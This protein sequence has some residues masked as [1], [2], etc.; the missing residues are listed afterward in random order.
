MSPPFA[1]LHRRWPD[2]RI[3][4]RCGCP[5]VPCSRGEYDAA[6][7]VVSEPAAADATIEPCP[8]SPKI[9]VKNVS[10]RLEDL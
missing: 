2:L 9:I 7:A 4:L 8:N 3:G 10:D 5:A 1:S 6:A